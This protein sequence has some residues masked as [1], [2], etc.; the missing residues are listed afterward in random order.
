VWSTNDGTEDLLRKEKIMSYILNGKVVD[1]L[2]EYELYRVKYFNWESDT[3]YTNYIAA[4]TYDEA[5]QL[6]KSQFDNKHIELCGVWYEDYIAHVPIDKTLSQEEILA[7]YRMLMGI[8]INRG[9]RPGDPE[10][11]EMVSM[12][13]G[14]LIENPDDQEFVAMEL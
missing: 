14:H 10:L 6:A 13:K 8:L 1:I 11:E 4:R 12:L 9:F 7:V 3:H 2:A 5:L